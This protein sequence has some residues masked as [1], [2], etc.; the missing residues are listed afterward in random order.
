M[1]KKQAGFTLAELLIA[2]VILGIIA[3]FFIPQVLNAVGTQQHVAKTKDTVALIEGSVR[4]CTLDNTCTWVAGT[5]GPTVGNNLYEYFVDATTMTAVAKWVPLTNGADGRGAGAVPAT[6]LPATHP[7]VVGMTNPQGYI[8]LKSGQTING[9]VGAGSGTT[10]FSA[11]TR[12]WWLCMDSNG[13]AGPNTQ[14]V[15][16]RIGSFTLPAANTAP[17]AASFQWG[18]ADATIAT[19]AA[20]NNFNGPDA[21][22]AP[23]T[24]APNA[25]AGVALA[26]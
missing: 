15:D 20:G 22:L 12:A 7:C 19:N 10:S 23:F 2:M 25:A 11:G 14:G 26:Q 9:L 5:A 1:M 8:R 17:N 6:V 4:S 18:A 13:A 21:L 16:V 3:S 24:A